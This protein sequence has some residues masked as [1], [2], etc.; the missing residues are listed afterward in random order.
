MVLLQRKYL[1]VMLVSDSLSIDDGYRTTKQ[2][3]RIAEYLH[4]LELE[5][6]SSDDLD[7]ISIAGQ[8]R[9][10]RRYIE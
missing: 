9:T 3:A 10:Y 4:T 7:A 2:P 8:G 5:A 1:A 6:L